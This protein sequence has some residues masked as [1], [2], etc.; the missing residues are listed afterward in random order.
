MVTKEQ[1]KMVL[2]N[3]NLV[4]CVIYKYRHIFGKNSVHEYEDLEQIGTVGLIK[5]AKTY[6]PNTKLSFSN[7]AYVCIRNELI[8]AATEDVKKNGLTDACDNE[9]VL[10]CKNPASSIED[11][12]AYSDL[13]ALLHKI[14][15]PLCRTLQIGIDAMIL[16]SLGYTPRDAAEMYGIQASNIWTYI[17]RARQVVQKDKRFIDY[18]E[19]ARRNRENS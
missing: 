10:I 19:E 9:A 1:E 4:H 5:A 7:Y 16:M 14:K 15:Q 12:I 17:K 3:K 8:S 13:V 11:E 6:N 18:T 2:D